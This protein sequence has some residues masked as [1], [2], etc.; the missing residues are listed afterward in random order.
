[1]VA[2]RVDEAIGPDAPGRHPGCGGDHPARKTVIYISPGAPVQVNNAGDCI[3]I[4]ARELFAV[5]E[6]AN[7]NIYA[8]DPS[9][10]H[11][12]EAPS[13]RFGRNGRP[14]RGTGPAVQRGEAN[15]DFLSIL[16]ENTGGTA[17][18][19]TT[20][21]DD[22]L[23]RIFEENGSYYLLGYQSTNQDRDGKFRRIGRAREP[24]RRDRPRA[25]AAITARRR[26]RRGPTHGEGRGVA[27][28]SLAYR[29]GHGARGSH[30][31]SRLPRLR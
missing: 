20:D 17:V 7:V 15:L 27:E 12:L 23:D 30:C 21:F 16:S 22:G 31:A 9:G 6:R 18:V 13:T 28:R 19:N 8:I 3:S 14:Q 29:L 2:V 24:P 1:V 5:A 4:D 25:V 10:L 11:A 26:P